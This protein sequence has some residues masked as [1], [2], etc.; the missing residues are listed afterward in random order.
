M[1][2]HRLRSLR[3]CL[4]RYASL[5]RREGLAT[6]KRGRFLDTI[7]CHGLVSLLVWTPLAFGAVHPWA[8]A[9]MEIHVFALIIIWMVQIIGFRKFGPTPQPAIRFAPIRFTLPLA[10][11]IALLVWQLTPLPAAALQ[12]IAPSTYALYS[13]FHPDWPNVRSTLS[14]HPYA[15]SI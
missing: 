2:P 15:T 5:Q 14:L 4:P 1:I 7:T 8:Y 9:L 3:P 12:H 6:Q 13:L 10:L 11:F